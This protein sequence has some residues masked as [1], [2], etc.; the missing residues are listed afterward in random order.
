MIKVKKL[1]IYNSPVRNLSCH[2]S[3][4]GASLS[5]VV[6]EIHH[7]RE[8]NHPRTIKLSQFGFTSFSESPNK[9]TRDHLPEEVNSRPLRL[10]SISHG[11][12]S[13]R[14]RHPVPRPHRPPHHPH[15]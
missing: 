13:L 15:P 7:K 6:A 2:I 3:F 9:W 1:N 5:I 10:P 11:P 14:A 12:Q 8:H 4:P